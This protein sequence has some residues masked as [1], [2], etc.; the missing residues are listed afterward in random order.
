MARWLEEVGVF[1]YHNGH[2]LRHLTPTPNPQPQL[3]P[4]PKFADILHPHLLE[5]GVFGV[6]GAGNGGHSGGLS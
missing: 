5:V 3:N 4:N 1:D 6:I 2:C